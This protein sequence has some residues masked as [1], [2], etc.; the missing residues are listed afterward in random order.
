M[1]AALIPL[2]IQLG[3]EA[4]TLITEAIHAKAEQHA[5]IAARL[6]SAIAGLRGAHLDVIA[7]IASRDAVTKAILDDLVKKHVEATIASAVVPAP[8]VTP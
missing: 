3:S 4:L 8:A 6:E 7:A 1:P 5:A 2:L